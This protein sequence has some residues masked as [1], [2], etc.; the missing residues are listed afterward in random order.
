[1]RAPSRQLVKQRLR[2]LQIERVEAFGEPLVDRS[3]KIAGLIPLTL[4]APEPRHAHRRAQ[5]PRLSLL[6]ASNRKRTLEIRFRFRRIWLGRQ[7]RDFTSDAIGLGLEPCFFGVFN[8]VNGFADAAPSVI[9]SAKL[10]IRSPKY[11]ECNGIQNAVPAD[12]N[13]RPA[14][15]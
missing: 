14:Y 2:F 7:Q 6:G 5:F 3:E 9:E 13:A 12:R 10:R 11:D 15:S 8:C 4:I 1:M